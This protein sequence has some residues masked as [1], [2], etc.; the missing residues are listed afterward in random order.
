LDNR[1]QEAGQFELR[2]SRFEAS[3]L[4][5]HPDEHIIAAHP[6]LVMSKRFADQALQKVAVY[7]PLHCVL[8]HDDSETR[9]WLTI[10]RCLNNKALPPCSEFGA[11]E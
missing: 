1:A 5:S 4:A 6:L 11:K 9:E 7:R 8:S 3:D 2:A 10:L